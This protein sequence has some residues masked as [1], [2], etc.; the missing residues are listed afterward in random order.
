MN[1]DKIY[2]EQLANEYAP[3]D[4]SKVVALKKLDAK[5]KLPANIFTYTLG[6]ISALVFGTGMWPC[7]G[8]DRQRYSRFLCGGCNNRNYRNVRNDTAYGFDR[9]GLYIS[10]IC[11]IFIGNVYILRNDYV[12]CKSYKVPQARQ[13]YPIGCKGFEFC[14]G[15]N[16]DTR[17]AN[18]DDST[19]FCR[20]KRLLQD[21]ERP[22]GLR[23]VDSGYY[24]GGVYVIQEQENKTG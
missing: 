14:C 1:T 2:A 4:T 18:G 22:G 20:R 15:F 24:Y 8:V 19:V 7:Y 11:Y 13:S 12:G 10:R 3:K 21:Y 17:T 5:A 6:V 23:H 16:V 9:F